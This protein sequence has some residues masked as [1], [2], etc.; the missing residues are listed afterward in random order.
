MK[1]KK[2]D[3]VIVTTGKDK[4]KKGKIA[5]AFPRE[6][7]VL[8]EG[9]NIK[10][11]HRRSQGEGKPGQ[12]IERSYPIHVSN[13]MILDPKGDKRTRVGYKMEKGKKVRIARKSG[14]GIN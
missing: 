12:V 5:E 7:K 6:D 9:V 11:V 2:G 8:I 1:I 10:K 13:V 3:N 4:G 14:L